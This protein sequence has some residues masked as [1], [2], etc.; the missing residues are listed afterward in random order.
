[1]SSAPFVTFYSF[2]GGVGRSM[3]VINIA[4]LLASRGFRVLVLDL[5]LEAPGIS[6]LAVRPPRSPTP[7]FVELLNDA[8]TRGEDS[9]LV[10]L[11]P[12]AVVDRYT[13]EYDLPPSLPGLTPGSLRVMVAGIF[14]DKYQRA[15][16]VLDIS[17]L[18]RDGRGQPLIQ[19]F[20]HILQVSDRF[21]FVLIDSRT[22]FSD[23]AGI[24]TRDLADHLFVVTGLNHQNVAGTT[25]FLKVLQAATTAARP[26]RVVL[27]PVPD[28]EEDLT[29]E[30]V[31]HAQSEFSLAW[32]SP[33]PLDLKIHYHPRL[34]LTE[35]PHVL[36]VQSGRLYDEY[37]ALL[38]SLLHS[39]GL[40]TSELVNLL[41][42]SLDQRDD[43]AAERHLGMLTRIS[44]IEELDLVLFV[45]AGRRLTGISDEC[46]KTLANHA[47][48]TSTG[49]H[50]LAIQLHKER[51]AIAEDVYRRI[52]TAHPR[53][54]E[55]LGN[56]AYFM[57]DFRGDHDEAERLFRRALDIAPGN[58]R[59]LSNFANFM[60]LVRGDHD[61]AERLFSRALDADPRHA[62]ILGSLA[63][64]TWHVRGNH[65]EAERLFRRALNA[66]PRHAHILGNFA[67]FIWHVRNDLDEAERL[68]R[69]ALTVDSSHMYN[70]GNF[71]NFAWQA[72]GDHDE[73][74]RLLR[75]A[76]DANP[77][78]TAFLGNLATFM[79]DV[80][81]D[82]D[83]AESLYRRALDA[84]PRHA[85]NLGKFVKFLFA[86]GQR[87]EA[88][89]LLERDFA[90][91]DPSPGLRCE[92]Q[93]YAYAH[94]WS[95][96]P[97][98]LPR[99]KHL[100]QTNIR[101]PGWRLDANVQRARVD[102]HPN[103]ALVAAL[104][105]VI[106]DGA[107]ITDLDAFPEWTQTVP[108]PSGP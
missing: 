50:A 39:L 90:I 37:A 101:S 1:M 15:L 71:G 69:R 79:N 53:D 6:Y 46:L 29:A 9:D 99:L 16:N 108:Q 19:A 103:P 66:D 106:A 74:E 38:R 81:D 4:A 67:N 87:D 102:H 75:R 55:I 65:D 44:S 88:L 49:L 11:T 76:L 57:T 51:R 40:S 2:K 26:L 8:I 54:A 3:A 33:V 84:D 73:A 34:A 93:F 82:H 36:R 42:K 32:G 45:I 35:E 62:Q 104:A 23:E 30:R 41:T 80:R 78:E 25:Q 85:N 43:I 77:G 89:A 70:L 94:A 28:G 56:F 47:S 95:D 10:Q 72:R 100:L 20:K 27:S 13:V 5:D 105:R 18:Y 61:E 64:F 98:A 83:E 48:A 52:T 17:G 14:D 59:N 68:F 91:D 63:K 24:C 107:P 96:Y 31:D 22:G 86:R 92:L 58:A 21:D 7:G 12:S 97:D 60:W